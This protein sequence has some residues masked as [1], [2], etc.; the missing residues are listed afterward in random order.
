MGRL[1]RVSAAARAIYMHGFWLEAGTKTFDYQALYRWN[2]G[3]LHLVFGDSSVGETY[4][5]ASCLLADRCWR[6]RS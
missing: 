5:D 4:L 6:L 3:A 2:H 1:A